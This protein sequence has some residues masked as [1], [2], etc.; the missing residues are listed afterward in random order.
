MNVDAGSCACAAG[1]C[2]G[3]RRSPIENLRLRDQSQRGWCPQRHD[4]EHRHH[5]MERA[6]NVLNHD[7]FS[8]CIIVFLIT[9]FWPRLSGLQYTSA[10]DVFS[11]GILLW[12]IVMQKAPYEGITSIKI[13]S[14]V[15]GGLRPM[16][17]MPSGRQRMPVLCTDT[18]PHL[19]PCKLCTFNA[20]EHA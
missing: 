13:I 17:P 19:L 3:H 15:I 20:A 18:T 10:V 6:R 12:E 11:F 14:S 16:V 1:K 9:I 8:F 7:S 4:W 2:A 5:C